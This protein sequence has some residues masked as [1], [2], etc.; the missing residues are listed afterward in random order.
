MYF[1]DLTWQVNSSQNGKSKSTCTTTWTNTVLQ[2]ICTMNTVSFFYAI[3]HAIDIGTTN[4]RYLRLTA[5]ALYNVL[6]LK[7]D[8]S[9]EVWLGNK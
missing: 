9:Q 7:C 2:Y 5:P 6:Y 1:W 4:D 3:S 8:F